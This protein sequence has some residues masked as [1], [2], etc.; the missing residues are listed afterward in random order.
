[1]DKINGVKAQAI[2]DLELGR[3]RGVRQQSSLRVEVGS[4]I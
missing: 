2:G 3:R 4:R 1:M